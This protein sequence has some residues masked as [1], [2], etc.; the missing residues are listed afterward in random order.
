[1]EEEFIRLR[2]SHGWLA[3]D[4]LKQEKVRDL[5]TAQQSQSQ[6][7]V[8]S[9]SQSLELAEFMES[10]W[11][12]DVRNGIIVDAILRHQIRPVLWDIGGGSGSV[13]QA[14]IATGTP[15]VCVEQSQSAAKASATRGISTI[16]SS[17]TDLELP[18][19]ALE[20]VSLFD[21]LEHIEKRGE[22]LREIYRVLKPGGHLLITVPACEFLRS[23]ID[24]SHYLRYSKRIIKT[25]LVEA[26]FQIVKSGY[27]FVLPVLPILLLR[28]LPYRLGLKV[29]LSN[30]KTPAKST[31]SL[32]RLLG[33]LERRL[34]FRVPLGS[35]IFAIA[36]KPKT[37]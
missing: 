14:L 27:F 26:G 18:D 36:L 28:A 22:M 17:L 25:E 4:H 37:V 19:V 12:A 34:A 9:S 15:T 6:G 7:T 33:W 29:Y 31:G 8:F 16:C 21:V 13:A 10:S 35:S 1:M 11:W 20:A 3:E 24:Q 32:T 23:Q 5:W 2:R 30:E